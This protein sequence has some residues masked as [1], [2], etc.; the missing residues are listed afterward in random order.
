LF[1]CTKTASDG[2]PK[3]HYQTH[4][5]QHMI[6]GRD[7]EAA[8][9]WKDF[10]GRNAL[11]KRT[12]LWPHERTRWARWTILDY[13]VL[14]SRRRRLHRDNRAIGGAVSGLESACLLVRIRGGYSRRVSARF[15]RRRLGPGQCLHRQVLW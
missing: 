1:L 7:D 12:S 4:A 11:E 9:R 6:H 10:Q 2:T 3:K 8:R 13:L 15:A 5:R 14:L